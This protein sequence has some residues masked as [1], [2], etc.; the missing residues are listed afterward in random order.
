MISLFVRKILSC[1]RN[2]LPGQ[3]IEDKTGVDKA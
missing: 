3:F 2:K 1:L